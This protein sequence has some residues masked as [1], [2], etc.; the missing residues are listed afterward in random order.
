MNGELYKKIFSLPYLKCLTLEKAT[1]VLWEIHDEVYG[2]HS[3]PWSL[4]GKMIK[5]GYFWPTMQKDAIELVK[6]WDKCQ[7]FGNV[8]YI[9]RELL[10]SISSPWPFS[11][12]EIDIIGPLLWWKKQVKFLLIAIDYFTEWVQAKPLAVITKGKIQSF[13]WKNIVCRFGIPKMIISN[14]GWQLDRW[15]F[16][17]FCA[18]LGIQNH[19]SSPGHP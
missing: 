11:T 17:E 15:K 16:K 3:G 6:K 5:A 10:T 2:N 8:Q 1:Y 19:Y 13:F 7:C 9:T 14:N 12:W 18:N 4:V